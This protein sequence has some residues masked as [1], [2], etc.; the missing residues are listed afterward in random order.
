DGDEILKYNTNPNKKDTDGG[1]TDDYTEISRGTNPLNPEDDVIL[2]IKEPIVLEGVTFA[3]GSSELTPESEK[4][5]L[6][7]LNTLNAYP[8]M[9]VE[10][11]GYTDNVGKASSNQA[12]SQ[13]RANSVRYW[14]LNKGVNQDR[15]VA[16]GYGEQNPIADN[17]TADGRRLNRRIEF[18]KID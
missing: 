11:R 16:K 17:N 7:V 9:N 8:E 12:L 5:L 14:L 6:K 15:V 10:I 1:T 4:M 13:R 2:D 18:V 3:T